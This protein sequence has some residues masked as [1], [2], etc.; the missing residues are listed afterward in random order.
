M[1]LYTNGCLVG[2]TAAIWF[3]MTCPAMAQT[4]PSAEGEIVVTAQRREERLQ[5]TPIAITALSGKQLADLGIDTPSEL[6]GQTPGL[7][8][9]SIFGEGTNPTFFMRGIG[10]LDFGDVTETPVAVNLDGVYLGTQAAQA[11]PVFDVERVEVLKGPQGTLYGRN[12]TGGVINIISAA[13]TYNLEG[14]ISVQAGS[15]GQRLMEGALSGPIGEGIRARVSVRRNSDNGWQRS[16]T[17]GIDGFGRTDIWSARGQLALDLSDRDTLLLRMDYAENNGTAV[18]YPLTGLLE[19]D[20]IT[21]CAPDRAASN[22]CFNQAGERGVRNPRVGLSEEPRLRNKLEFVLG[23]ATY[24]HDFGGAALTSITA[25]QTAEKLYEEDA[26]AAAIVGGLT[27]YR[28]EARQFSQEL[29]LAGGDP[30]SLAWI[31]GA[32]Y[33][34]EK[35]DSSVSAPEAAFDFGIPFFGTLAHQRTRSTALFGQVDFALAPQL[36]ATIG[37]RYTADRKSIWVVTPDF[38]PEERRQTKDSK[39]TGRLSL[40][41]KPND[42]TL[43]YASA[44][45]GFKA[46]GFNANFVFDPDTIEPVSPETITS[47]EVGLKS[48]LFGGGLR[49]N[50]ALFYYDYR[51]IQA[52]AL[53]N[54]MGRSVTRLI[55]LGNAEVFGFDGDLTWVPTK[56]ARISIGLGLLDSELHSSALSPSPFPPGTIPVDGNPLPMAPSVSLNASVEYTFELAQAGSLTA[57]LDGNWRDAF[58]FTATGSREPTERSNGYGLLNARLRWQDKKERLSAEV[59]VENLTNETY[60]LF[61]ANVFPDTA[62]GAWGKPRT[63]GVRLQADF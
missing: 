46:G 14:H 43:V 7:K 23:T 3:P 6:A 27:E 35:R 18:L 33:F 21:P 26:D 62:V 60:L 57:Q 19:D 16:L 9:L 53:D 31:V 44:S 52:V 50:G 55:S 10:L 42:Q 61:N 24:E 12:S 20:L 47:Y 13:P 37:G 41:W 54:V 39:L 2:L 11:A 17:T 59:F 51:D 38:L 34:E 63:W 4:S 28:L 22:L 15:Y 58:S 49:F 45:T 29:R 8:V 56:A 40:N 36:T 30:T 32:Y 48:E 25:L 5:D 1:A